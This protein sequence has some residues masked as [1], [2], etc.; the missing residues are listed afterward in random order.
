MTAARVYSYYGGGGKKKQLC[1]VDD[2]LTKSNT[3][4]SATITAERIARST[5]AP[6][7]AAARLLCQTYDYLEHLHADK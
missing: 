7:K 5:A 3:E 2:A 6:P 1:S 4:D